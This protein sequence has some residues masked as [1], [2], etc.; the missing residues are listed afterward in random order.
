MSSSTTDLLELIRATLQQASLSE[1][2]TL[3]CLPSVLSLAAAQSQSCE[4]ERETLRSELFESRRVLYE[5]TTVAQD[6]KS[7]LQEKREEVR[8]L[9]EQ[10]EALQ[11][12]LEERS[13]LLPSEAPQE[14][15]T[16]PGGAPPPPPLLQWLPWRQQRRA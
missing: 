10:L 7:A 14:P 5:I 16:A 15:E 1:F 11:R 13:Q 3:Q 12:K 6:T 9:K 4:R 2:P 8:L